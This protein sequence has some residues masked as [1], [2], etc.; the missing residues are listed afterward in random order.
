V[1]SEVRGNPKGY[2]LGVCACGAAIV[3][4]EA[5]RRVDEEGAPFQV[6]KRCQNGHVN[7]HVE[8]PENLGSRG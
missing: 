2:E 4:V 8:V 6:W 1:N 7:D 5:G 3:S